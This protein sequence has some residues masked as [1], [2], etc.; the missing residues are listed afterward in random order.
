[1]LEP[2][3]FFCNFAL[4]AV[5][6]ESLSYYEVITK[7]AAKINDVIS[8]LNAFETVVY[9]TGNTSFNANVTVVTKGSDPYAVNTSKVYQSQVKPAIDTLSDSM[10]VTATALN[11]LKENVNLDVTQLSTRLHTAEDNIAQID[12]SIVQLNDS[13]SPVHDGVYSNNSIIC[14]KNGYFIN[15]SNSKSN[16]IVDNDSIVSGSIKVLVDQHN[17]FVTYTQTEVGAIDNRFE[18]LEEGQ[19][20]VRKET[21]RFGWNNLGKGA[22]LIYVPYDNQKIITEANV[23]SYFSSLGYS[24]STVYI[25]SFIPSSGKNLAQQIITYANT[26]TEAQRNGIGSVYAMGNG[27]QPSDD[28]TSINN[29]KALFQDDTTFVFLPDGGYNPPF[30]EYISLY[31]ALGVV[32][33]RNS[34]EYLTGTDINTAQVTSGTNSSHLVFLDLIT[35]GS[36]NRTTVIDYWGGGSSSSTTPGWRLTKTGRTHKLTYKGSTYASDSD[37]PF[38]AGS[39]AFIYTS[40]LYFGSGT[41]VFTNSPNNGVCTLYSYDDSILATPHIISTT[42]SYPTSDV[43]VEVPLLKEPESR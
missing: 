21:K 26:L 3:K 8:D 18:A 38:G 30:N 13:I 37:T 4:P 22:I 27:N 41:A 16:T 17:S 39:V 10:L 25:A 43:T 1:M 33:V 34:W 12:Q 2:I 24:I 32:S 20:E 35:M 14:S 19:I 28:L 23:K 5:Y 9:G 11:T 7:L 40:N 36:S 31:E 29:M 6:D 42:G 15:T